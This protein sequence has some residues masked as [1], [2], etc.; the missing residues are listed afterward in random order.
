[1]D[2]SE[3]NS[4]L[5]VALILLIFYSKKPIHIYSLRNM[6]T[7]IHDYTWYIT[8]WNTLTLSSSSVAWYYTESLD[9]SFHIHMKCQHNTGNIVNIPIFFTDI[10]NDVPHVFPHL[11]KVTPP[12]LI[13]GWFL[14]FW[15]FVSY[16]T[17]PENSILPTKWIHA[18]LCSMAGDDEWCENWDVSGS[19]SIG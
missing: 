16:C 13:A 19:Y 11:W 15:V 14:H 12:P 7:N 18:L 8:F 3:Q 5:C 6:F 4:V 9:I 10:H 1:M 2:Y 17:V